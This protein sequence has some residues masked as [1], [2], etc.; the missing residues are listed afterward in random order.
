MPNTSPETLDQSRS[1]APTQ[2]VTN[3][4]LGNLIAKCVQTGNNVTIPKHSTLNERY[5]ILETESIGI[6]NG[7]DFYLKYFTVG[8]RGSNC[9]GTDELGVSTMKV[10]QH[11]PIDMNLFLSVPF[12]ARP[13]DNDFDNVNRSKY[14]MRV[15]ENDVDGVLT[16][17]YY[18]KLINFDNY[19]P[20]LLKIT[21]DEDGNELTVPFVPVK[22][23]LFDPTPVDFTSEGSVPTSN[24]YLNSSAILDCSLN[25][26]DLQELRNACLRKFGDESYAAINEVGLA[27]GIDTQTDGQIGQ[28]GVIRYAESMSTVIA[29]FVSE[30]DARNARNNTRIQLAFDHGASDP[31]LLHSNPTP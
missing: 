2:T 8:I 30:R 27:F 18:L 7:R 14:R 12:A 11:Q 15:V 28:G 23:D 4:G 5:K 17:F 9:V 6:K 13:V 10:N 31:M 16:A 19:D 26:G 25:S 1:E 29:H 20:S 22:D 21:R 3:T 24:V